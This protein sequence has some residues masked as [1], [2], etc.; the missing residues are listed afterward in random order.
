MKVWDA[1]TGQEI[2]HAQGT[3]RRPSEA[4]R[5]APTAAASPPASGDETVKV[6]D[7]G[8]RPGDAHAQ[9][10]HRRV[11]GVAFS[12]D[13]RRIA[14]AGCDR[15]VKVWDAGSGQETL[16]LKGHTGSSTA[17]RTAPTAAASP[18]PVGTDGEGLGWDP[19]DP[20]VASGTPGLWPIGGMGGLSALGGRGLPAP[21][22]VVRRPLAPRSSHRRDAWGQLTL[23]P[24][25]RPRRTRVVRR[26][27][28]R[29]RQGCRNRDGHHALVLPRSLEAAPWRPRGIPI[30]LRQML[31]QFERSEDPY[32]LNSIVTIGG[33]APDAVTDPATGACGRAVGRTRRG[34]PLERCLPGPSIVPCRAVREE[35]VGRLEKCA[36]DEN[37]ASSPNDWLFLALAHQGLGHANEA[38]AW[39]GKAESWL[40]RELA[41][42]PARGAVRA[43]L[44]TRPAQLRSPGHD[45]DPG[46]DNC[47]CICP[48]MSS[49]RTRPCLSLSGPAQNTRSRLQSRR[50]GPAISR[51]SRC[52][53]LR[54]VRASRAG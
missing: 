43:L 18:R 11:T 13:G 25:P 33:L 49:R 41:E 15:T 34:Q 47:R 1:A 32:T 54:G 26:S 23:A 37:S 27:R 6:W 16:T 30:H 31:E 10:T 2:A 39:L 44:V 12:P 28:C 52:Q 20:R 9:G 7:A 36:T 29:L 4:W 21:T 3:H 45:T 35:S 17:W 5:T 46:S 53:G 8:H 48:P 22:A 14:S 40:D 51:A 42:T 19:C 50:R 24:R 38:Q